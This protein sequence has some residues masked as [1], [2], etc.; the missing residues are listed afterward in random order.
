VWSSSNEPQTVQPKRSDASPKRENPLRKPPVLTPKNVWHEGNERLRER[1]K[2]QDEFVARELA[3]VEQN[4]ARTREEEEREDGRH[5]NERIRREREQKQ[6]AMATAEGT[7][8][9]GMPVTFVRAAQRSI[10]R[11][12][13]T[14]YFRPILLKISKS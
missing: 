6:A 7:E 1:E 11:D 12:R 8:E 3:I 5:H 9:Q 14:M 4:R 13:P 2:D 10:T